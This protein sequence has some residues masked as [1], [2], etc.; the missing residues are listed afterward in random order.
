MEGKIAPGPAEEIYLI[1]FL[2]AIEIANA[3]QHFI[4]LSILY[5]PFNL[6]LRAN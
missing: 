4:H 5:F 6:H 3:S 1:I 2:R